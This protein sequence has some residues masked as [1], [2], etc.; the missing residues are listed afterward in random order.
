MESGEERGPEVEVHDLEGDFRNFL[1]KGFRASDFVDQHFMNEETKL[2]LA[3]M[4]LENTLPR[5][6]RMLL[7]LVTCVHDAEIEIGN[8]HSYFLSKDKLT[9]FEAEVKTLKEAKVAFD[10]RGKNLK[11]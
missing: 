11:K 10:L 4:P 5:V 7:H 9:S 6:Q 1:D 2:V 3:K 8:L